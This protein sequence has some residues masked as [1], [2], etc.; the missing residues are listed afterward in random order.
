MSNNNALFKNPSERLLSLLLLNEN[1]KDSY[2]VTKTLEDSTT[3]I[4]IIHR[5]EG[6]R[7]EEHVASLVHGQ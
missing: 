4:Q 3:V 7:K 1:I 6:K 2:L 5:I